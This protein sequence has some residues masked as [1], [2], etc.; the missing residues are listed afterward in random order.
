M[1]ERCFSSSMF[2]SSRAKCL[3]GVT[4]VQCL[5]HWGPNA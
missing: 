5:Y 1:L 2:V 4:V 3:T